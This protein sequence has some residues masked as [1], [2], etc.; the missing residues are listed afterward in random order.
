MAEVTLSLPETAHT[1]KAVTLHTELKNAEGLTA[2]YTLTRTG[3]AVDA[4]DYIEGSLSGISVRF[5]E[6]GV[7]AL[8]VSV[9]DPTGRVFSDTAAITVYPVGSAGFFLPEIFHTDKTVSVE[10]VF[11]EI[12]SHTAV[13][14]LTRDGKEVSLSGASRWRAGQQR[15]DAPLL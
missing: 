13:W 2:V 7:Y 10:A 11:G 4:A 14:S 6:K 12:G 5:K 15:R 8:T 9:T 1:D 3:E